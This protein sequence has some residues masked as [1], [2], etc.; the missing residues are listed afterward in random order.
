MKHIDARLAWV[1]EL[2]DKNIVR[3]IKVAGT[4]NPADF[5][6][7]ILP[8]TEFRKQV[9]PK[10]KIK[11]DSCGYTIGEGVEDGKSSSGTWARNDATG[12]G[13]RPGP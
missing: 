12:S 7:K 9:K 8:A 10:K 2:R 11:G 5:Y 6:T 1:Q 13:A 4:K 3:L